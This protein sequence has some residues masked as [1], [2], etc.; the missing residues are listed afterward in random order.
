MGR[1]KLVDV[2]QELT[3]EEQSWQLRLACKLWSSLAFSKKELGVCN[4]G[5]NK[6][7]L[8]DPN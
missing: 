8:M 4:I 1:I 3:T 7:T 2:G 5:E 6:V